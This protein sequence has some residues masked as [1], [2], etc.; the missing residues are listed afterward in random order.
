MR[1]PSYTVQFHKD[2]DLAKKR[3]KKLDKLKEIMSLLIEGERL[4]DK[5][6]DHKLVGVF[7]NFRECHIESDWLLMYKVESAN[8]IF[9]RTG[10]H[11]DLFD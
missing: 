9:I 7:K 5:N 11:T 3:G 1:T 8:I 10:T 4:P 6:K 2:I